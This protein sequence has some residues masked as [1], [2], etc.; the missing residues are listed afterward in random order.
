[1]LYR[2]DRQPADG[3]VQPASCFSEHHLEVISL[4]GNLQNVPFTDL[5]AMCFVSEA[6]Q[7]DLFTAHKHFDR[8]P[9]APGLWTRFTFR[10]GDVLDG[11]L[12][13]N[14]LEWP[15]A[16]Y[17]VTPPHAGANRQRAFL[18]RA[19][20]V[21]TELRGVVGTSAPALQSRRKSDSPQEAQLRMFDL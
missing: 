20:L 8:R 6:G 21:A 9:K 15:A 17:L 12:S 11:V 5:K 18:P 7:A 3:I 16:G 10:D 4:E 14:L 19:A 1:M 13:H 2:F